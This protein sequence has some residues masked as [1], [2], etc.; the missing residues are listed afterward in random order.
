MTKYGM[1]ESLTF[2]HMLYKT[3]PSSRKVNVHFGANT[4]V[5]KKKHAALTTMALQLRNGF[6]VKIKSNQKTT[7]TDQ[8]VVIRPEAHSR[9][10]GIIIV[11]GVIIN[12]LGL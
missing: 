6:K 3:Q 12:V 8:A 1:K 11:M 4:V 7:A 10:V 5:A 9:R 2:P